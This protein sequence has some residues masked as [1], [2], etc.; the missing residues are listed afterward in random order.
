MHGWQFEF[1][2]YTNVV[3]K[4]DFPRPLLRLADPNWLPPNGSRQFPP[5]LSS[6]A[7]TLK[8]HFQGP[9]V[10]ENI[11]LQYTYHFEDRWEHVVKYVG[12]SE[13]TEHFACVDGEGCGPE[14]DTLAP[15]SFA[16]A[17]RAYNSKRR[18]KDMKQHIEW[19]EDN[20]DPD[21]FPR[22][23]QCQWDMDKI[24]SYLP[25]LEITPYVYKAPVWLRREQ[26]EERW[27]EEYEYDA[28]IK[29]EDASPFPH[30]IPSIE[31]DDRKLCRCVLQ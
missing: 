12:R 1:C 7:V 18:S 23:K 21:G 15:A 28:E 24:N 11:R 27:E 4:S 31:R 30:A 5:V 20:V 8:E 13:P 16:F 17:K 2:E 3:I 26:E 6:R 14:E 10:S 29:A 9:L 19:Y 25:R 22:E